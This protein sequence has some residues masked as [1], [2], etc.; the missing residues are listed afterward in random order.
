MQIL[1]I[2]TNSSIVMDANNREFCQEYSEDGAFEISIIEADQGS[3]VYLP[4]PCINI[5]IKS[6]TP[7]RSTTCI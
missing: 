7:G 1:M 3:I 5:S 6:T 4:K 2:G